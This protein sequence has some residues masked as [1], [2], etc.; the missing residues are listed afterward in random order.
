MASD[1]NWTKTLGATFAA[2]QNLIFDSIQK[3][4]RQAQSVGTLKT[5]PQQE[6]T[7]QA[8]S[9]G[10]EVI[11]I[12]PANPQV[13][14]VPQYNPQVVYT[15][16]PSTTT[17]VIQ[18]DDDDW[19]EAVAAGVIGFTAGV[20]I[21]SFYN[22]YHY[23]GYGWYGGGYMYNDGWDDYLDHREDAREDWADHR[24]DIAED[25]GDRAGDRQENRSDRAENGR[26]N[27]TDRQENRTDRGQ[28][29]AAADRP[30]A[31]PI[32]RSRFGGDTARPV[33][34][35]DAEC[36]GAADHAF[37]RRRGARI[38]RRHQDSRHR[39]SAAA[40][41]TRSQAI[42]AVHRRGRRAPGDSEAVPAP[43]AAGAGA[44]AAAGAGRRRRCP[45]T[46]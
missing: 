19:E 35:G 20:A 46:T 22:P 15:Q 26:E 27:R 21:S 7:T 31:E 9:S 36:A 29:L 13:V 37:G 42:R 30:P 18:E 43:G 23:G 12:E 3:L 10:E 24:E 6:V 17:V 39:S 14:Y 25:R 8:T 28:T 4:R 38:Q 40:A 32:R 44:A 33:R 2:N 1:L 41:R 34:H 5:T 45:V 11:I 16:A